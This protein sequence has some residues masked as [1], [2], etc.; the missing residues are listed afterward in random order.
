MKRIITAVL[1]VCSMF[2]ATAYGDPA[3]Q[4]PIEAYGERAAIRS[5]SMSPS[6]EQLAFIRRIDGKEMLFVYS[7]EGGVQPKGDVTNL[8]GNWVW[9]PTEDHIIIRAYKT[10]GIAG[11]WGT[12]DTSAAF[13]FNLKTNKVQQLLTRTPELHPAQSGLGRIEGRLS[14]GNEVLMPAWTGGGGTNVNAALFK[15]DLDGTRGRIFKQGTR[16]TL[17]WLVGADG[18]LIAREDMHNKGNVYSIYS[19]VGG[20][21]RRIFMEVDTERPPYHVIGVKSD[22]SALILG[23]TD[24]KRSEEYV[25]M[26]FQGAVRPISI[27]ESGKRIGI[28]FLSRN[29]EILGVEY[30]GMRPSYYLFDEQA[31]SALN[32]VVESFPYASVDIVDRS[33]DWSKILL[34]LFNN[35]SPGQ[36]VILDTE[37]GELTGLMTS[38]PAIPAAA[39]GE[40]LSIEYPARDGLKIPALLTWPAGTTDADRTNLPTIIMPHGGPRSYDQ[41]GFDW[42]AQYFANRGYL[43]LQPNFRGSSGFTDEFMLAGNGEWGGKMQ[44]DVSDG[45]KALVDSGYADPERTCIIGWSY[46]GYAALAG[47]AFTP[48]LYKCVVAVAPVTDL[49]RL[50]REEKDYYGST[51]FIFDYWKE[52]IGDPKTDR[53]KLEATSPINF[54]DAFT[55]PVLL[56][57]AKDD[58]VVDYL[59]SKRMERALSRAG[60]DVELQI[61]RG[62]GH[63]LVDSENRLEALQMISDFVEAEIGQ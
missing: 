30:S 41:V 35:D 8:K 34:N 63:S 53:T 40:V 14:G 10:A 33:D 32:T 62:D 56:I 23:V 58:R 7:E 51:H 39:I 59:H 26:D 36:Y 42:L 55:A 9:F 38:R 37:T 44:D 1:L 6:G 17:D 12:V 20:K 54:A 19:E 13:S 24:E 22:R 25:E 21:E 15:V 48:D 2:G 49:Q 46:G 45:L 28:F 47:G 11:Y 27:G 60:K 5:V 43:V 3:P 61:I 29:R 57:H 4:P 31:N 16:H 50:M 18:T 52:M